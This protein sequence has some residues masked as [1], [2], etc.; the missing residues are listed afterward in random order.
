MYEARVELGRRIRRAWPWYRMINHLS[1]QK[2]DAGRTGKLARVKDIDRTE[3]KVGMRPEGF[4]AKKCRLSMGRQGSGGVM[5]VKR[6]RRQTEQCL[7]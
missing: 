1:L 5:S 3:G 6:A 4:S 7:S 2:I